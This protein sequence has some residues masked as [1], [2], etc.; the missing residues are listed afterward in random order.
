M[1]LD[2]LKVKSNYKRQNSYNYT[3]T[4]NEKIYTNIAFNYFWKML[5]RRYLAGL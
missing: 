2:I 5:H 1:S 4:N 3:E